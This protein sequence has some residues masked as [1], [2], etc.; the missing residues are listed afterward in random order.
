MDL[1][2][3]YG[4]QLHLRN[5]KVRSLLLLVEN[6]AGLLRGGAVGSER[7]RQQRTLWPVLRDGL[8]GCLL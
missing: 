3:Y 1:I 8:L 5:Q 4:F 7:D 2:K 6:N